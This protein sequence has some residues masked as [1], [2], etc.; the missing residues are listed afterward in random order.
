MTEEE[1]LRSLLR[2]W[3]APEPAAAL[4]ERVRGKF[5]ELHPPWWRRLL[6]MRV[7]VPVPVMAAVML[8][9]GAV[10]WFGL[11]T[12]PPV[13]APVRSYANKVES[14]GFQPL[15]RGDAR[16]IEVKE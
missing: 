2:E 6:T 16:V 15:P 3:P 5:R 4:D 10:L 14:A 7:S 11:R 12:S 9:V 8:I 1:R 13:V